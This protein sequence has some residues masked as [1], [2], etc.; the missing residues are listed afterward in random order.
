MHRGLWVGLIV[1]LIVGVAEGCRP[2]GDIKLLVC[3][4]PGVDA[5]KRGAESVTVECDIGRTE[6]LVALPD[7]DV[8]EQDLS[9]VVVGK[10]A[11]RLLKGDPTA[12]GASR[13]CTVVNDAQP[14]GERHVSTA[15]AGCVKPETQVPNVLGARGRKFAVTLVRTKTGGVQLVGLRPVS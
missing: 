4:A 8:S 15:S 14:P 3:L 5:V 9:R 1:G 11:A 13:L 6:L 12:A 2:P 7:R 10:D